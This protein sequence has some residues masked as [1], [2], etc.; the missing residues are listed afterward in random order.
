MVEQ[1]E[2]EI[3]EDERQILELRDMWKNKEIPTDEY[4]KDRR[5]I[6]ARIRQNEKKNRRQD[7][8]CRV[9]SR[10]NRAGRCRQ[11]DKTN[12]RAQEQHPSGSCSPRSL[13]AHTTKRHIPTASITGEST[14]RKT[15]SDDTI[16]ARKSLR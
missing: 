8:V 7:T 12:R 1:A 14:S 11:V 3:A 2:R 15:T 10:P 4:R 16:H 6:Q 5:D 13:S 9:D